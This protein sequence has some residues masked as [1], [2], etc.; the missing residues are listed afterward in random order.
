MKKL[1]DSIDGL[2]CKNYQSRYFVPRQSLVKLLQTDIIQ[3]ELRGIVP[4]HQLPEIVQTI[5][6]K[7]QLIFAILV[8]IDH[9]EYIAKFI[10]SDQLQPNWLDHRL[11]FDQQTLETMMEAVPASRFYEKQ[12]EFTAP[13]FTPFMLRRHLTDDTILPFHSENKIG[14]GGFGD[15]YHITINT[16]HQ[17]FDDSIHQLVRK[18]LQPHSQDY[19]VEL[20]NLSTLKLLRHPN[21][22]ELL[23]CYT[24]RGIHSF[25]F[26]RAKGGDL[27]KFL[28]SP[29]PDAFIDNSSFLLA[30]AG[31]ASAV[32]SVHNFVAEEL[33]L[34]YIG[35]HHDLK[36]AN[37]LV[38]GN[39]FI[40]ADFGLARFKPPFESSATPAKVRHG[41]SIAPECQTL[42][43]TF[44]LHLVHRSSDIWSLGC[45]MLDVVTYMLKGPDGV[46]SFESKREFQIGQFEY[47]YY[48][49]GSKPNPVVTAWIEELGRQQG[50]VE[51]LLLELI[52]Q[53]LQLDPQLRPGAGIVEASMIWIALF[54]LSQVALNLFD[55]LPNNG[56]IHE[57]SIESW[58]EKKRFESWMRSLGFATLPSD[59][60][61]LP[62]S[63]PFGLGQFEILSIHLKT[64]IGE[65][66][67]IISKKR[68]K[69][70]RVFLPLRRLNTALYD[71]LPQAEKEKAQQIS[72]I[73]L[74]ESGQLAKM[75]G[76][77]DGDTTA[78]LSKV[79]MLAQS[80][81]DSQKVGLQLK[82]WSHDQEIARPK[83]G[84]T[85][86]GQHFTGQVESSQGQRIKVII[87]FKD[88]DD[89]L[90]RS[91]LYMRM[92][93]ISKLCLSVQNYEDVGLLKCRGYF[94]DQDRRSFGLVYDLP[95]AKDGLTGLE[96]N[97]ITLYHYISGK[98]PHI[99]KPPLGYRFQLALNVAT[100][101]NE[102]HKIGWFHKALTSSNIIMYP[103]SMHQTRPYL[104]GFRHSR[105]NETTTFT[106]GPPSDQD[107][108]G[109]QH[110]QYLKKDLRYSVNYDYYSLG[111]VLLEIGLWLPLTAIVEDQSLSAEEIRQKVLSKRLPVLGHSM[112]SNYQS[113]VEACLG[114]TFT[115]AEDEEADEASPQSQLHFQSKVLNQ[116]SRLS[117]LDI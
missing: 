45:I 52:A 78:N 4:L 68:E 110:P 111:I 15:V 112:G 106:E 3:S 63:L 47:A 40:L 94:H 55:E 41:F 101:L 115:S 85:K 35:C 6:R 26:P 104:V 108:K 89:P 33:P 10:E 14:S 57:I 87:D 67:A 31:L 8:L 114:D 11:P 37:I 60:C 84:K 30:L 75:R 44:E 36:A 16:A 77:F 25:I 74:L 71:S 49:K 105:P 48:H 82:A 93:E 117:S 95:E 53:C 7:G 12:W 56:N 98:Q 96:N 28:R 83:I 79:S 38:D 19:E 103:Q 62:G 81:H 102:V 29:L 100:S 91:K 70:L 64:L 21:I 34:A 90:L 58:V 18:D 2:R 23:G 17:S 9:L 73:L 92:E 61:K 69:H 46:A 43:N 109:Y 1:R 99:L 39:R 54:S 59:T 107:I 5:F 72:E 113:I 88:Y 32:A 97:P 66:I 51:Q 50:A 22:S 76:V 13:V 42:D 86:L 20:Q 80:K 24:Y 116:L 65:L 27:H